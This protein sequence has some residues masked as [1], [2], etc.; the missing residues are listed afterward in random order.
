MPT[1]VEFDKLSGKLR[2]LMSSNERPPDAGSLSYQTLPP[3]MSDVDLSGTIDDIRAAVAA[4]L[5]GPPPQDA[6]SVPQEEPQTAS[7]A[8]GGA[9][10]HID[11]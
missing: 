3:G 1:F 10:G 8:E 4:H 5:G 7:E 9:G 2:R 11:G 6:P